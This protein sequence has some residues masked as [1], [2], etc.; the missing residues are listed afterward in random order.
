[1]H[2]TCRA[3]AAFEVFDACEPALV[4][5]DVSMPE[6]TGWEILRRIRAISDV[7]VIFVSGC[8]D[9]SDRARGLNLGADDYLVKPFSIIELVARVTALLRRARTTEVANGA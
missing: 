2:T 7:P 4:L 8:E 1:V 3:S 5:L 9:E 6:L